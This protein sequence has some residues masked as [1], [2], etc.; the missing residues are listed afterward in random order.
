MYGIIQQELN[1]TCFYISEGGVDFYAVDQY[2][3]FVPVYTDQMM[4]HDYQPAYVY[5]F[6]PYMQNFR[7]QR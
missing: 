5:G 6:H 4:Y 3:R 7:Q 1:I 2:G